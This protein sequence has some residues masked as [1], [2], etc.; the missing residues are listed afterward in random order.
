MV[1]KSSLRHSKAT[2]V[3]PAANVTMLRSQEL[4][5]ALTRPKTVVGNDILVSPPSGQEFDGKRIYCDLSWKR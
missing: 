4:R 2:K 3:N 1:L 5:G